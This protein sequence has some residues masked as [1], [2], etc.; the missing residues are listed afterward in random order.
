MADTL[1][2]FEPEPPVDLDG[3]D[4][5]DAIHQYL[6]TCGPRTASQVAA[7]IGIRDASGAGARKVHQMLIAMERDDDADRIAANLAGHRPTLWVAT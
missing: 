3:D 1:F 6:M 2:D 5:R 4:L 7:G